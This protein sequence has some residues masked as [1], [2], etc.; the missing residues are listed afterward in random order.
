MAEKFMCHPCM[1]KF[2]NVG[3]VLGDEK[4]QQCTELVNGARC[5]NRAI[6]RIL[7][8]KTLIIRNRHYEAALH[9]LPT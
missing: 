6:V 7:E 8:S 9:Q 2:P 3:V 5:T 1:K 4:Y